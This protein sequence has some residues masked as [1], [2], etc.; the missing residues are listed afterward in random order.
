MKCGTPVI[1]GN[2]TSLP[3]VVG[4]AAVMVDPFSID[5]IARGI[6]QV[7]GDSELRLQLRTKGFE[8]AKLFDWRETARKT[9][10]VYQ[11]AGNVGS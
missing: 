7:V 6:E 11:A 9:L 10:S 5:D 2:K 4:N 3:E 1:V 8:Q